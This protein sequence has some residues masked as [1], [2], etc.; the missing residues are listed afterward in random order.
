VDR[1]K[2]FCRKREVVRS[3]VLFQSLKELE[4]IKICERQEAIKGPNVRIFS[5]HWEDTSKTKGHIQGRSLP[6]GQPGQ[7]ERL[8]PPPPAGT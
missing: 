3:V 1:I 4:E 7:S 2:A 6:M 5:C 8:A